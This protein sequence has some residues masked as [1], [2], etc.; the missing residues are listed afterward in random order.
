MKS[1]PFRD[2][3]TFA[4]LEIGEQININHKDCSAGTDTKK[5]L[6]IKRVHG[7]ILAFCQHCSTP[8]YCFN[9][10]S[11]D[12]ERLRK[13]I[14]NPSDK[15][16]VSKTKTMNEIHDYLH[17][18]IANKY[19]PNDTNINW[20]KTHLADLGETLIPSSFV[21]NSD[22]NIV[23]P[24]YNYYKMLTGIQTRTFKTNPKY[25]TEYASD[26]PTCGNWA[27]DYFTNTETLVITED[28]L[29]AYKIK[30]STEVNTLA[31]LGTTLHFKDEERLH[32][33]K[34]YKKILL[35]LDND[36]AGKKGAE[37]LYKR[38]CFVCPG[39]VDIF[40]INNLEAKKTSLT[41]IKEIINGF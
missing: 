30:Q 23:F 35:W 39:N 31:L 12:S 20:L 13:W 28:C 2:F 36:S 17:T 1:L 24:I 14:K 41:K 19:S 3:V 4:P 29:S 15:I 7:G 21:F 33:E 10:R 26:M 34:P 37:S 8:G 32:K 9:D 22:G 6:Y 16:S 25:I 18:C 5:R 38:L 11:K 27:L 40:V